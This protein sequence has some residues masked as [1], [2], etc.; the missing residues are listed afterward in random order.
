MMFMASIKEA[1]TFGS[2][3]GFLSN[4]IVKRELFNVTLWDEPMD[5]L[6]FQEQKY[7]ECL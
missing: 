1:K 2:Y 6:A 7:N 3:I 4:K 5:Y